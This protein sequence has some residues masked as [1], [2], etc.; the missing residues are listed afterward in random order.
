MSKSGTQKC[1]LHYCLQFNGI[2]PS[3]LDS[4]LG[5]IC[6]GRRRDS[7]IQRSDTMVFQPHCFLGNASTRVSGS[8]SGDTGSMQVSTHPL[9]VHLGL[10]VALIV[11]PHLQRMLLYRKLA[12]APIC[13]CVNSRGDARPY[14]ILS[15]LQPSPDSALTRLFYTVHRA[16]SACVI[17]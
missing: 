1:K 3:T 9:K 2:L 13:G 7:M 17:S 16:S 5:R 11:M 14:L 10:F 15:W 6:V 12:N 8:I 4:A